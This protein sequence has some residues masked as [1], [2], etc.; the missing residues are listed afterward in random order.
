[1]L[2]HCRLGGAFGCPLN[3]K[4]EKKKKKEEEGRCLPLILL[5][6]LSLL[7]VAH[8]MDLGKERGL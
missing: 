3:Q 5:F 2:F 1:M 7:P 4:R 6:L 8:Y